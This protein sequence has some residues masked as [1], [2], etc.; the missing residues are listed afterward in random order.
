M[1]P[2]PRQ[3]GSEVDPAWKKLDPINDHPGWQT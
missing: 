1:W 2:Q 3:T